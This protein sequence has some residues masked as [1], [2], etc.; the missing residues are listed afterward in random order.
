MPTAV[1]APAPLLLLL[2]GGTGFEVA[3][4]GYGSVRLVGVTVVM[5]QKTTKFA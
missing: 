4:G 3:G 2:H 5:A 1:D